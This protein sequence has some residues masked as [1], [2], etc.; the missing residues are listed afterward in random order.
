MVKNAAIRNSELEGCTL[1]CLKDQNHEMRMLFMKISVFQHIMMCILT[2]SQGDVKLIGNL[3]IN[4]Q[5]I[6]LPCIAN[7]ESKHENGE[8]NS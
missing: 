8:Q 4:S 2:I 5:N 1:L 7:S 3:C 6:I